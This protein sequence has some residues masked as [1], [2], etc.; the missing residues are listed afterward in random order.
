MSLTGRSRER[1]NEVQKYES[2]VLSKE[3]TLDKKLEA[4]EKRDNGLNRKEEELNHKKQEV[5]A[6]SA[7]RVQELER[8]SGLTSDSGKRISFKNCRRRSKT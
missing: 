8:I 6:L 2:R 4:V 1:S 5:E 7:K 3:E